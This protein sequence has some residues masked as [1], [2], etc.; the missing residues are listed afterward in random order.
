MTYWRK[1]PSPMKTVA[2]TLGTAHRRSPSIF[3]NLSQNRSDEAQFRMKR[4]NDNVLRAACIVGAA[5]F[6]GC[7]ATAQTSK[8]R[9]A[10]G[11]ILIDDTAVFPE[12]VT[13]TA[14]GTIITGSMKG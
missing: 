12:S 7:V 14:D 2:M 10:A 8:G 1:H 11:D 13:S 6:S 4:I 5:L 9:S 3:N